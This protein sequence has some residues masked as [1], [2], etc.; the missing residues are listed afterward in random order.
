MTDFALFIICFIGSFLGAL[1]AVWLGRLEPRSD[2]Q[3]K[4]KPPDLAM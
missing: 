3:R 2:R 1:V 4:P